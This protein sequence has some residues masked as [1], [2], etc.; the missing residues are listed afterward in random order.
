[1]NRFDQHREYP[2]A[3]LYAVG[4][5]AYVSRTLLLSLSTVAD[6]KISNPLWVNFQ[7]AGWV[8]FQS[9]PTLH[10]LT[11]RCTELADDGVVWGERAL[12]PH[13]RINAYTRVVPIGRQL[14][15][16][17]SGYSGALGQLLKKYPTLHDS[18]LAKTLKL[19]KNK[20]L[21]EFRPKPQALQ[22]LF[23]EELKALNHPPTEWPFN[24]KYRGSRSI[25][26]F[27]QKQLH[28]HFDKNV[29]IYHEAGAKAHL[30]LGSGKEALIRNIEVYDAWEI[31]SHK[32]DADFTIGVPNADGLLTY[33][34]LKRLNLLALVDRAS[35]AVIWF[36]VVYS[37]EVSA[38]DVVRLISESLRAQLPVPESNLLGMH[39]KGDAGFPSERVPEL[40]HALPTV[41]MPDN[42]LSNLA[43]SVSQELRQKLG[44]FLNYGPPGHFECRPNVEHTFKNIA[45]SIF[46][47]LPNTTGASPFSGK[48]ANGAAIARTY[49]MEANIVEELAYH[50]FAQHN[51]LESEGIGFLTPLEF[52][53]QKMS[54]H[55]QHVIP[56]RL[57]E[58]QVSAVAHYRTTV[59]VKV[60]CYL[61]K[62][63]RP[64]INLDRVRY[65]NDILRK[66]PWLANT[67]INIELDEQDMRAVRAY[68]PD[69]SPI[70]VLLAAGKWSTT[71]HSRKTRKAINQLKAKRALT[72][73]ELDDP[74]EHYLQHLRNQ[75]LDPNSGPR[76]SPPQGNTRSVA[77]E[78]NRLSAEIATERP[79]LVGTFL[80]KVKTEKTELPS[81][82]QPVA[83]EPKYSLS[84]NTIIK[85]VMPSKIPDLK[86]L[87]KDF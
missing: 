40:R 61:N 80:E 30:S 34:N 72:I 5:S 3:C 76:K 16:Q 50:H 54:A 4:L 48:A 33:I 83:D 31:D 45:E 86:G 47:R 38:S 7:S 46:Q 27:M 75:V 25:T 21:E 78:L 22:K 35:T 66:S 87:M 59:K 58:S 43:A 67:E 57:L 49:K 69:G 55:N 39:I 23:I 71:K 20:H 63:I 41:L 84:T 15:E 65:S 32:I 74:V 28:H 13:Y 14:P 29:L 37:S 9:A 10:R 12:I 62:G 79:D 70:G 73:S 11:R 8:S 53:R 68:F 52:I 18:L 51:A 17:K 64:F 2:A 42:A 26:S 1:M 44:F 82:K 56:R 85:S 24:T 36:L 6:A 19:G 77:T 60:K 81:T